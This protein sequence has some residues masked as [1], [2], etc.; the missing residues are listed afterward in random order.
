MLPHQ[1]TARNFTFSP[2]KPTEDSGALSGPLTF[3]EWGGPFSFC[4]PSSPTNK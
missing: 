2:K 3:P 4:L 1:T